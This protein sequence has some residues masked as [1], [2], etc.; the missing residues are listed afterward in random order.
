[1]AVASLDLDE[2]VR[3]RN[4]TGVGTRVISSYVKQQL[5]DGYSKSI[6]R[7]MSKG[8]DW[9]DM[10]NQCWEKMNAYAAQQLAGYSLDELYKFCYSVLGELDKQYYPKEYS[11]DWY[12]AVF[13]RVCRR[14]LD[15]VTKVRCFE[16]MLTEG[17]E[18]FDD[19]TR[20]SLWKDEVERPF[21][22]QK[23]KK[24]L[25]R[26]EISRLVGYCTEKATG[27][28]NIKYN[29]GR[30][31]LKYPED[32]R[33]HAAGSASRTGAGPVRKTTR[34]AASPVK[35]AKAGFWNRAGKYLSR[36]FR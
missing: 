2:I 17:Y 32:I 35:P 18:Y 16:S 19:G 29:S 15:D 22:K 1:M 27:S 30:I 28:S 25:S 34:P 14:G 10:R 36:F 13:T 4:A 12:F 11:D 8:R 24:C 21:D 31:E 5:V 20:S 33:A 23:L 7:E 3:Y 26:G 9:A 6:E